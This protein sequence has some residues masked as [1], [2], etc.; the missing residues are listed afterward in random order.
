M[1]QNKFFYSSH[2]EIAIIL[3][4][5]IGYFHYH[6]VGL[7]SIILHTV[8]KSTQFTPPRAPSTQEPEWISLTVRWNIRVG[9]AIKVVSTCRNNKQKTRQPFKVDGLIILNLRIGDFFI[10]TWFFI[11]PYISVNILLRIS[12][13]ERFIRGMFLAECNA[14]PWHPPPV[15]ILMLNQD[16]EKT[17][18]TQNVYDGNPCNEHHSDRKD[19]TLVL[20]A[21]L[22][23][24]KP[25]TQHQVL[26]TTTSSELPIIE[27]N[28]L[29]TVKKTQF[30]A[31]GKIEVSPDQKF[32]ILVSNF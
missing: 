16:K 1:A 25:N 19:S 15:T 5:E 11:S 12:S 10:C 4:R 3:Y 9:K 8:W 32:Y 20:I 27:P 18:N 28:H 22:I 13:I 21:R 6:Q 30:T 2:I 24:L 26:V 17:R 7:I 14:V 31:C 23:V 29:R